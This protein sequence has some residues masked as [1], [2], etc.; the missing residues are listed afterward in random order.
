MRPPRKLL[1]IFSEVFANGGLQRFNRTLLAASEG[2]DIHCDVY[3]LN[4]AQ[5][6]ATVSNISLTVFNQA[7]PKFAQ[8]VFR[9]VRGGE[10]AAVIIGHVNFVE[11]VA[12]ALRCRVFK[13]PAALLITHGVDVWSG[14][15]GMRRR[16]MRAVDTILCV[17]HYTK[18]MIQ[19]QAPELTDERFAIFPNALNAL[20][21]QEIG[22][23]HV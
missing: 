22:R 12:F 19:R 11:L 20:W 1:L 9:A 2:L 7:K 16:A 14:I 17:S 3:S 6:P 8:A 13:R 5:A 18:S 21:T 15:E 4:D 10:Y 23:A